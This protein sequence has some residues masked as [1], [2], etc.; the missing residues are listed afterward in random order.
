MSVFKDTRTLAAAVVN[1]VQ[2]IQSGAEVTVNDT[3]T[4]DN[5]TR[6]VPSLLCDP[7]AYTVSDIGKLVESGYYQWEDIGGPLGTFPLDDKIGG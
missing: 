1:M 5:D 6:I 3:S 4:Y 7:V 2:E